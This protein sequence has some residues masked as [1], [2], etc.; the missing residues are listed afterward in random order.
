MK[1]GDTEIG[2][3]DFRSSKT[4]VDINDKDFNKI[5]I[6]DKFAHGK[7][8]QNVFKYFIGYKNSEKANPFCIEPTQMIAY[9][10]GFTGTKYM[11]LL[12]KD[13]ELR[14]K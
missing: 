9:V 6:S 3:H 2:K 10:N 7:N 12:I 8:K 14:K 11:S 1:F 5:L 13:D 4:T